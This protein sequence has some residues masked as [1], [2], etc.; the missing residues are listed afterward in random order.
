MRGWPRRQRG[1]RSG[2]PSRKRGF[3]R[4]PPSSSGPEVSGLIA[5]TVWSSNTATARAL[6]RK[7]GGNDQYAGVVKV[8]PEKAEH[9]LHTAG[10]TALKAEPEAKLSPAK[11]SG[12][13]EAVWISDGTPRSAS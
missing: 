11:P 1:Y 13:A 2:T 3:R 9:T 10:A 6:Y 7:T 8:G 12:R 4:F 5:S